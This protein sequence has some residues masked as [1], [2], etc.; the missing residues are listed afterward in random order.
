MHLTE[1]LGLKRCR[2]NKTFQLCAAYFESIMGIQLSHW[3]MS[4]IFTTPVLLLL[5]LRSRWLPYLPES[6]VHPRSCPTP[7]HVRDVFVGPEAQMDTDLESMKQE[8][9]VIHC[10]HIFA[11]WPFCIVSFSSVCVLVICKN[12]MALGLFLLQRAK[13]LKPDRERRAMTWHRIC[14]LLL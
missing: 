5:L 12:E 13:W 10:K 2:G 11:V 7:H 6:E 1:N 4:A 14:F 8:R 9:Q 3:V